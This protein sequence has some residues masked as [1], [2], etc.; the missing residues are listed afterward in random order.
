MQVV[1]EELQ[2]GVTKAVLVG[3]LDI[4]GASKIDIQFSVLAG[5][6]KA[7]VV[8]IAEVTFLA[9]MGLRTLMLCAR[10]IS[11]KGGRM[12][13]AN[14]QENVLRVLTESGAHDLMGVHPTLDSAIVYVRG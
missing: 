3:R 7:L 4:E 12:A 13:L 10:S 2:D 11:S 8:D 6:K 1:V 9:S 5:A 14:P